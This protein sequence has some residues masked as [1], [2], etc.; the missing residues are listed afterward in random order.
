MTN[1]QPITFARPPAK[2]GHLFF[3]GEFR[4]SSDGKIKLNLN[5]ATETVINQ[6]AQAT[7]S[8]LDDAVNAARHAFDRGPWSRM[9]GPER[10]KFLT[11]LAD[12]VEKNADELAYLESVDVGKP[13]RNTLHAEIPHVADIYRYYADLAGHLDGSTRN[14]KIPSLDPHKCAGQT[15]NFTRREPI[16]V[17]AGITPFNFPLI[18]SAAKIAPALAAG[19]TFIHKPASSTPLTAVRFAQ[20][21]QEADFP[22]GVFNVLTGPGSIIGDALV[23]HPLVDKVSLTGS[24]EVGQGIIRNSADTIKH[25]TM[26]LGG[27]SAHIVL[28]DAD[29]DRAVEWVYSGIFWNSGELCVAGSRLVIDRKI[30]DEF[31]DKLVTRTRQTV[32]GDPLNQSTTFGPQVDEAQFRKV[33]DYVESGKKAGAK[34]A[35]GGCPYA[36]RPNGKGF[37]FEPTIFTGVTN[38]MR[39]AQEEIFGPVLAVICFDTIEEAIEIANGTKYGLAS[40]IQTR[41][42]EKAYRIAEAMRAG[43]V[44][45]NTY[46]QF[47]PT[48]PFGGYKASGY[49]REFGPEALESYSQYKSIWVNVS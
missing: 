28:D 3:N 8:D 23:K 34:I 33:A 12:S 43:S 6:V 15:R 41:S 26:E 25:V 31:V 27:K 18:L 20:I 49:G 38:D 2:D 5:P 9:S 7:T 19:N 30:H 24:T 10:G 17:V 42:I 14:A 29:M 39:I 11:R 37:F 21:V 48:T 32:I 36:A 45:I 4:P 13:I 40:G 22:P 47:D 35:V 16:G 44:W 1:I 46:G